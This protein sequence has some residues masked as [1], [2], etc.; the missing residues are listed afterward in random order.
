MLNAV[1]SARSCRTRSFR[2]KLP[3]KSS[4]RPRDPRLI[5]WQGAPNS[6]ENQVAVIRRVRSRGK[7]IDSAKVQIATKKVGAPIL[8]ACC[9]ACH[10]RARLSGSCLVALAALAIGKKTPAGSNGLSFFPPQEEKTAADE[11]RLQKKQATRR[12][13]ESSCEESVRRQSKTPKALWKKISPSRRRLHPLIGGFVHQSS[14]RTVTLH[15]WHLTRLAAPAGCC[16]PRCRS[17][18]MPRARSG[19]SARRYAAMKCRP[20]ERTVQVKAFA[21]DRA[22]KPIVKEVG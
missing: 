1:Q 10:R 21:N 4:S 20:L 3:T 2:T 16:P 19:R 14:L 11:E 22:P 5:S 15:W 12:N 6:S 18:A 7:E 17:S 9:R 13:E 8:S